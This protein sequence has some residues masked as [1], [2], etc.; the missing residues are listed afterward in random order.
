VNVKNLD[1]N[2]NINI[3]GEE[4]KAIQVPVKPCSADV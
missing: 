3:N 2:N 4:W 1:N